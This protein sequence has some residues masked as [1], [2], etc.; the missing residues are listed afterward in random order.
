[1]VSTIHTFLSIMLFR[2]NKSIYYLP[3]TLFT[4]YKNI[5]II[6]IALLELK[7]FNKRI[8]ILGYL[9][10]ILMI[11]SSYPSNCNDPITL[12]G[13]SWML[14]NIVSTSE[15]MVYLKYMMD[16][17]NSFRIE[18]V[19]FCNLLSLPI[20]YTLSLSYTSFKTYNST[21]ISLIILSSIGSFLTAFSTAWTLKVYSS[22]TLS[23]LGAISKLSLSTASFLIFSENFNNLKILTLLIKIVSGIIYS[24]SATPKKT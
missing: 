7:F 4:L 8:S 16:L 13:Y 22:T 3:V 21:L 2:N 15:Y 11:L 6:L 12:F 9:S 10:F 23:M 14:I 5:S 17:E 24:F 19:F 1:M 18:A 20:F